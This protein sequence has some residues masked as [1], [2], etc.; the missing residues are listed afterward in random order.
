M[1]PKEEIGNQISIPMNTQLLTD[2]EWIQHYHFS[3]TDKEELLGWH[4]YE[5]DSW[6]VY[7]TKHKTLDKFMRSP[8]TRR[9]ILVI[10]NHWVHPIDFKR[11]IT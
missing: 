1:D 3:N 5:Y 6:T 8:I 7:N 9:P 4:E 10:A 2:W 11:D